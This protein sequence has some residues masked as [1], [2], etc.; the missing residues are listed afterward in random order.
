[1]AQQGQPWPLPGHGRADHSVGKVQSVPSVGVGAAQSQ[2]LAPTFP[3]EPGPV[4]GGE[5]ARLTP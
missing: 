1:M 5:Q 2:G 4:W 3:E